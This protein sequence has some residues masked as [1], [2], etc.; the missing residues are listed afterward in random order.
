[1]SATKK[2]LEGREIRLASAIYN[3]SRRLKNKESH[4][5]CAVVRDAVVH[6]A[7]TLTDWKVEGLSPA[8]L[9]A[10][11]VIETLKSH[12][13]DSDTYAALKLVPEIRS[14]VIGAEPQSE[15]VYRLPSDPAGAPWEM[16]GDR[17][18]VFLPISPAE[19]MGLYDG[20]QIRSIIS[21]IKS[22]Q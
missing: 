22:A 14:L 11:L 16:G 18:I 15:V 12:R 6:G 13:L 10:K 3:A 7:V 20:N 2:Q 9:Q 8:K 1:M 19:L 21:L 4:L 5:V 17:P